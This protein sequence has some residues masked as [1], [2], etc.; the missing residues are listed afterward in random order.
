ARALVMQDVTASPYG[1]SLQKTLQTVVDHWGPLVKGVG[2][3]QDHQ[4]PKVIAL[5]F[6]PDVVLTFKRDKADPRAWVMEGPTQTSNGAR[7]QNARDNLK[8]VIAQL[9]P[10][11][12][13]QVLGDENA[14]ATQMW[15]GVGGQAPSSDSRINKMVLAITQRFENLTGRRGEVS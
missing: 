12:R 10:S 9:T 8:R 15:R 2:L 6:S 7:Q 13:L 5:V 11:D 3:F 4:G 14:S 1:V